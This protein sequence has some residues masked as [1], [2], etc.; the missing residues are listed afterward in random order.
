MHRQILRPLFKC[1]VNAALCQ[2]SCD[3]LVYCGLIVSRQSRCCSLAAP[4]LG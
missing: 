2:R 3:G 4:V 1:V